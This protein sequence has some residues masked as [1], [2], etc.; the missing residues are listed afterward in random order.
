MVSISRID[1]I[2]MKV[3]NLKDTVN[4]YKD[5]FGFEVKE[6]GHWNGTPWNII[7]L[8]DKVYLCVYEIG[9]KERVTYGIRLN[10]FG[11]HVENFDSLESKLRAKGVQI[12]Y[13]GVV[14][15]GNSRSLYI[16]DPS[17]FEI[18]LAEFVGGNLH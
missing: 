5:I 15:Q 11:L 8:K 9:N 1:Y 4:F 12:N 17:G 2:N 3:K 7:G 13:G 10:H 14:N 6:K 16:E 18:E